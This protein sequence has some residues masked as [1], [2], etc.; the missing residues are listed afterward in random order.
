MD[1][2]DKQWREYMNIRDNQGMERALAYAAAYFV[3]GSTNA[4]T[5]R[6]R[7]FP[8]AEE[9]AYDARVWAHAAK[10]LNEDNKNQK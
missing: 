1:D 3:P 10:F 7:Y 2:Q 8:T 4:E 9:K 6:R 5:I